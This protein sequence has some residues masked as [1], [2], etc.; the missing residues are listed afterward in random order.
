MFPDD[1]KLAYVILKPKT[2]FPKSLLMTFVQFPCLVYLL[3][4]L[5]KIFKKMSC[6]L[7]K[8]KLLT[9]CQYSF[10]ENNSTELAITSFCGKL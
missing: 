8:K 5:K 6:F 9:P 2:S 4:Y 7:S 10:V 3:N 1:F